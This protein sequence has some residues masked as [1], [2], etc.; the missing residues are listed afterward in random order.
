M[1]A[2]VFCDNKK[3]ALNPKREELNILKLLTSTVIIVYVQTK[4]SL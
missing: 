1:G 4:I 2:A 3:F